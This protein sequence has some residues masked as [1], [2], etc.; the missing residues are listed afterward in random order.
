M[1]ANKFARNNINADPAAL[2]SQNARYIHTT[3]NGGIREA[4]MATQA[5]LSLKR[6][7]RKLITATIAENIAMKKSKTFGLLLAIISVVS[8]S[9][10]NSLVIIALKMK[11]K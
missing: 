1:I 9:K 6:V 7:K 11:W 10:P 4:A 3:A 2:K 8:I 5:I